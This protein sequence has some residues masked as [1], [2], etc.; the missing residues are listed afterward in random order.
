[1]HVADGTA[2][3]ILATVFVAFEAGLVCG[4]LGRPRG[5]A[6]VTLRR[7]CERS[8]DISSARESL[9][10]PSRPMG[11]FWTSVTMRF[12]VPSVKGPL[13]PPSLRLQCVPRRFASNPHGRGGSRSLEA[14][15]SPLHVS[16]KVASSC[17]RVL[18]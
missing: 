10:V 11:P 5:L 9:W 3:V 15:G 1:M 13:P 16:A 14:H 17:Q 8:K 4:G 18:Y 2:L 6:A 7:T 12:Q